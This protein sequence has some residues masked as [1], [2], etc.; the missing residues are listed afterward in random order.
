M[1]SSN[2]QG[3]ANNPVV[4]LLSMIAAIIAIFVFVT[5]YQS[6]SQ[7]YR[8]NTTPGGTGNVPALQATA[9]AIPPTSVPVRVP[10]SE[11]TAIPTSIAYPSIV[12]ED[13]F[14]GA[15]LD[16]SKWSLDNFTNN[17]VSV[18]GGVLRFSSSS[19]RSPYIYSRTNPFPTTG[20]FRFTIRYRYSRIDVCGAYISL[21][22][23]FLPPFLQG[24]EP[25]GMPNEGTYKV[26][27]FIWHE[28]MWYETQSGRQNALLPRSDTSPHETTIIYQNNQYR[29][30]QDGTPIFT[31]DTTF[32]RLRYIAFGNAA[33]QANTC[34]WDSL[35]IDSVRVERLP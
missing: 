11:P 20:D 34:S 33:I 7:I 21:T 24:Q 31:S 1:Q 10:V 22:S 35:E 14:S 29:V 9:P 16:T 17:F 2:N 27:F 19:D 26:R 4:V 18:G 15:A 30:S 12:F 23:A 3:C 8:P 13:D 25:S 5:G 28:V 32:G 6:L